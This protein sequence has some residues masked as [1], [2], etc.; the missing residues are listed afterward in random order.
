M[1]EDSHH[2]EIAVVVSMSMSM[3]MLMCV[4]VSVSVPVIVV[5]TMGGNCTELFGVHM[6]M[7][8]MLGNG[9]LIIVTDR[10]KSVFNCW[11][12]MVVAMVMSMFWNLSA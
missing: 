11:W 7:V 10:R 5:V 9:V 1:Y 6:L 2:A 8:M 3:I 4:S 12:T